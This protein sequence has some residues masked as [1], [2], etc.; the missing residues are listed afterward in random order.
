M[1]K[2]LSTLAATLMIAATSQAAIL[3][4]YQ[5]DG[6]DDLPVDKTP[7]ILGAASATDVAL[8]GVNDDTRDNVL[9]LTAAA[10]TPI[11]YIGFSLEAGAGNTFNFTGSAGSGDP[12]ANA[13]SFVHLRLNGGSDPLKDFFR[14]QVAA[15]G[16]AFNT[17]GSDIL[18]QPDQEPHLASVSLASFDGANKLDI[19]VYLSRSSGW[20]DIWIDDLSVTGAV[21]AIPEPSALALLGFGTLA[22]LVL[23]R[24]R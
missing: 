17:V 1:N 4:Q 11:D 6:V 14:V 3:V 2:L 21:A 22:L 13:L 12:A 15:D 9:G 5:F 18:V 20:N 10:N 19:R 7:S 8:F 16:G 23:G 24:R